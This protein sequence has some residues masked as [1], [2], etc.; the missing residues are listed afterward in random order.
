MIT[1]FQFKS[2]EEYQKACNVL[3]SAIK[4]IGTSRF[5]HGRTPADKEIRAMSPGDAK[6]IEGLFKH[7]GIKYEKVEDETS[8][9][10]P[11]KKSS[12]AGAVRRVGLLCR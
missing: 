7:K 11:E 4:E 2:S 6:V 3:D 10:G 9:V 1:R 12:L 8:W 5:D